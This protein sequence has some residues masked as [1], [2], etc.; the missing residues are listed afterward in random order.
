[1]V[2]ALVAD[3]EYARGKVTNSFAQHEKK[4]EFIRN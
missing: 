2:K 4:A 3:S 1:M